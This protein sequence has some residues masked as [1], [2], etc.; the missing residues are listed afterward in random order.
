MHGEEVLG[1]SH[2]LDHPEL[3]LEQLH[4]SGAARACIARRCPGN[5]AWPRRSTPSRLGGTLDLREVVLPRLQV[6]VA[7]LGYRPGGF[8]RRQR[9][10]QR[11]GGDLDAGGLDGTSIDHQE[12]GRGRIISA[13]RPPKRPRYSAPLQQLEK[14]DQPAPLHSLR[15]TRIGSA[16]PSARRRRLTVEDS[17]IL[18]PAAEEITYLDDSER[19]DGGGATIVAPPSFVSVPHGVRAT[20]VRLHAHAI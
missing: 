12:D 17:T 3:L 11:G 18:A 4:G 16:A 10:R 19:V 13:V 7:A 2:L 14:P 6:D 8:E 1:K 20:C 9:R 5:T 15:G